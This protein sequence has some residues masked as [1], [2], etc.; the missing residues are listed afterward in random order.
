MVDEAEREHGGLGVLWLEIGVLILFLLLLYVREVSV[1]EEIRDGRI[2]SVSSSIEMFLL[3]LQLPFLP[4]RFWLP[5]WPLVIC[6]ITFALFTKLRWYVLSVI[7]VLFCLMITA[8]RVYYHFFSSVV[9]MASLEALSQLWDIKDSLAGALPIRDA[10][11]LLVFVLFGVYGRFHQLAARS[12]FSESGKRFMAG[13]LVGIVCLLTGL[14]SLSLARYVPT[15]YIALDMDGNPTIYDSKPPGGTGLVP[16]HASS[17]REHAVLFGLLNFHAMDLQRTFFDGPGELTRE[18]LEEIA[19]K[20]V[21]KKKLNDRTSPFYGIAKGRNV[22]LISLESLQHF[23]LGLEVDGREVTPTLNRLRTRGLSFER[24]LDQAKIG[25]TS[26]AELALMT[27]LLPDV[28]SIAS[29][30]VPARVDLVALPATL[31]EAG[32][33]TVAMHAYRASFWNRNINLPR[34]GFEELIFDTEIE[35]TERV[36]WGVSDRAF[37]LEALDRLGERA[38]PFLAFLI[39]LSSHH[40]YNDV[41]E[42]YQGIFP[43]LSRESEATRYLELASYSDA[44]LAGF[45]ARARETPLWDNSLFVIYGDH[46]APL[47]ESGSTEMQEIIGRQPRAPRQLRI[48][49]IFLMPGLEETIAAEGAVYSQTIGGLQDIFPTVCHLLG[50][51]T[52]LGV[53]GTH[54]FVPNRE[55]DPVLTMR[56]P[57]GFFYDGILYEESARRPYRDRDGLVFGPEENLLPSDSDIGSDVLQQLLLHFALFDYDAQA[58]VIEAAEAR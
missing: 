11:W 14:Y 44:A 38:E 9:S 27:G 36:G 7:G 41:P 48:P 5:A 53:W 52:P 21:H 32:Y 17:H 28:R 35:A 42:D 55:R 23:L 29:L 19:E 2:A 54:L 8:D 46:I 37:L 24:V 10:A 51:E 34:Y 1:I 25:G 26:D 39:C 6:G 45:L 13:K 16:P 43:S 58:K 31:R 20:L 3:D 15:R 47:T 18:D 12:S 30:N 40:P 50:I 57:G 56:H 4:G 22:F 49:M 33:G